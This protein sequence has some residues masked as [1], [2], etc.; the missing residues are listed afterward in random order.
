[1]AV[2]QLPWHYVIKIVLQPM[3]YHVIMHEVYVM[4]VWISS[5]HRFSI[6]CPGGFSIQ[7]TVNKWNM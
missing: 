1:M 5:P 3:A 6:D 2:C 4:D 7:N